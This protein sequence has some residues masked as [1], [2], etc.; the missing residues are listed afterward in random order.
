M[1][2]I[3][4]VIVEL[5]TITFDKLHKDIVMDLSLWLTIFAL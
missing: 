4:L 5:T 1:A 2:S 3:I